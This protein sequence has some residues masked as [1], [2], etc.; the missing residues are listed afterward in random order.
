VEL[1]LDMYLYDDE[2][3]TRMDRR[4]SWRPVVAILEA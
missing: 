4:A 1:R 2:S 3:L